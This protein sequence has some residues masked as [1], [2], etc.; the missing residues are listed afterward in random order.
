[1]KLTADKLKKLIKEELENIK[2]S[3]EGHRSTREL[4][5][6]QMMRMGIQT[7]KDVKKLFDFVSKTMV[8]KEEARQFLEIPDASGLM[9][10]DLYKPAKEKKQNNGVK[11]D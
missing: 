5:L 2:E 6:V 9:D 10:P 3:D 1:M 11:N 8:F 4:L 7:T